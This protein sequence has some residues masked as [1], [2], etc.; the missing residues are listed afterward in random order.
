MN[1][2][3]AAREDLGR[4]MVVCLPDEIPPAS[5]LDLR[6]RGVGEPPHGYDDRR[7][8]LRH[9]QG[10]VLHT[11]A[12][13]APGTVRLLDTEAL[14]IGGECWA[15]VRLDA[16]IAALRG[17]RCVLRIP[18]PA[19]T[20]AG[21]AIVSINPPRRTRNRPHTIRLLEHLGQATDPERVLDALERGP[22]T[23]AVLADRADLEK[24]QVL[25]ILAE[26]GQ[27]GRA[28]TL[29]GDGLDRSDRSDRSAG[30]DMWAT[31]V[32]LAEA[33]H[34]MTAMLNDYHKSYPLRRG[35]RIEAARTGLGLEQALWS[36]LAVRWRAIGIIEGDDHLIWAAGHR[37]AL[38]PAQ[39]AEAT[40]FLARLAEKPYAPGETGADLDPELLNALLDSGDPVRLANDVLLRR[41]AY[42]TMREAVLHMLGTEEMVTVGMI[43]DRFTTSRKY[44]VALLEYLDDRGL[45]RRVGDGRVR[46][47]DARP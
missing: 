30:K 36:A 20:V 4:G 27:A 14:K 16:P 31:P 11:G 24:E 35:M 45:T 40:S 29:I 43:R 21:G 23:P 39:Q 33:T 38:N 26:L 44:A 9:G 17:D 15:Q 5:Y 19:A 37:V 25:T 6:L 3:G 12:A 28:I 2:A 13:E 46:G 1:L 34:R 22:A 41:E 18:S 32:W 7:P 10:I 8:L 42:D 47:P